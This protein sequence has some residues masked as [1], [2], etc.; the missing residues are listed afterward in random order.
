MASSSMKEVCYSFAA[1]CE[2]QLLGQTRA[3]EQTVLA[4]RQREWLALRHAP[5]ETEYMTLLVL[6][7]SSHSTANNIAASVLN[8]VSITIERC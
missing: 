3:D 1:S 8:S 7:S 5:R 4:D 2:Q 6:A